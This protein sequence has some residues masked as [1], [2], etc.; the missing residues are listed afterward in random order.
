ME[1][2]GQSGKKENSE[3]KEK[4]YFFMRAIVDL[5]TKLESSTMF[6]STCINIPTAYPHLAAGLH[7][8][9]LQLDCIYRYL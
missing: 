5:S 6:V 1:G 3:C 7:L 2:G 8:P 4:N 9:I